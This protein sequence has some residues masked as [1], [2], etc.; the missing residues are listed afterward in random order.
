MRVRLPPALL[1]TPIA[2]RGYFNPAAGI[3]ENSLSAFAAAG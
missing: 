3:P 2:H 1:S